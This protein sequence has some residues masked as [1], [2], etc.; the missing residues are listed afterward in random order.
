VEESGI[1]FM[2]EYSKPIEVEYE[3]DREACFGEHSIV[4]VISKD[5][6]KKIKTPVS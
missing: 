4:T 6:N 2:K 5:T 1:T 3:P